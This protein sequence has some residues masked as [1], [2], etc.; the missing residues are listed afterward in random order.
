SFDQARITEMIKQLRLKKWAARRQTHAVFAGLQQ[1]ANSYVIAA[2]GDRGTDQ[3]DLLT[4]TAARRGVPLLLQSMD[5]LKKAGHDA[6]K[7]AKATPAS[8]AGALDGKSSETILIGQLTWNDRKLGW[9]G[10]W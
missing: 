1:G 8:L 10:R 5:G 6:A 9:D 4:A 2:D 3:R 7:L